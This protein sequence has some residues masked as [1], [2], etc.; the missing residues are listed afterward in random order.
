[1]KA[2]TLGVPKPVV[3]S[4]PV[5]ETKPSTPWVP[6]VSLLLPTVMSLNDDA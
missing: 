5:V 4:Y 1:M 3:K 6:L 2:A